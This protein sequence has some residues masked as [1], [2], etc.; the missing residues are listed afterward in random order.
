MTAAT[1]EVVIKESTAVALDTDVRFAVNFHFL[2][3]NMACA[4]VDW[5]TVINTPY[6]LNCRQ[7]S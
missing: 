6:K 2:G 4:L 7:V 3:G 5:P 1:E